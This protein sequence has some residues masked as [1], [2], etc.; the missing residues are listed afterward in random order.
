MTCRVEWIYSAE[1]GKRLQISSCMDQNGK[2]IAPFCLPVMLLRSCTCSRQLCPVTVTE[3]WKWL[4]QPCGRTAGG[5]GSAWEGA[6]GAGRSPVCCS[7]S[8]DGFCWCG[9]LAEP[10]QGDRR[11]CYRFPGSSCSWGISR[12]CQSGVVAALACFG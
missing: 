6:M 3:A 8:R 5:P 7:R 12:P 1:N 10:G 4:L 9:G 2:K 11:T